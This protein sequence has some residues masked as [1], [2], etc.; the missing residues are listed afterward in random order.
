MKKT[1]RLIKL[2]NGKSIIFRTDEN[3]EIGHQIIESF[4]KAIPYLPKKNLDIESQDTWK[5]ILERDIGNRNCTYILDMIYQNVVTPIEEDIL[6][7]RGYPTKIRKIMKYM[8]DEIVNNRIDDWNDLGNLRMRTSELF[9]SLLT[10]QVNAA[11]NEYHSKILGGDQE[12][13]LYLNP[14][15]IFSEI[16]NSQ[17]VSTLENINPMEELAS[18]TK[19]T[20]IGIGGIAKLEAW[21][22][23][24]M[25]IHGSYYGN[26]DPYETPNAAGI[27]ILQHLTLGAAVTNTRGLFAERSRDKI[28][29]LEISSVG[30]SM[31]PFVESTDG[32]RVTMAAGQAKQAVPLKNPEIP[33]IQSGFESTFTNYLSDSFIKR[34]PVDGEVTEVTSLQIS[35][36][37]KQTRK[38]NV[39]D[40]SAVELKSG[41]GKSGLGVFN[42][43]VKQGEKVKKRQIIAEGSHIKNGIISTGLNCLAA[44]MPYLG[45]NFEDGMVI[46]QSLAKRFTSIHLEY[47][48]V[49]LDENDDVAYISNIGDNVHKGQI[50]LSYSQTAHDTDTLK[51]QRSENGI[52]INIEIYNN[53]ND[54]MVPEKL[55]D[56]YEDFKLRYMKL[57]GSY[58]IGQFKEKGTKVEGILVKFTIQQELIMKKG[59]KINNRFFNKG[60][61]ALIEK[62]ELMPKM[63]DGTPIEI[64]YSTLSVINRMNPSQLCEMHCSMISK[65]LAI[66]S[67]SLPRSRFV[68]LLS[69]V[70]N[71]LDS[72]KS[73]S[74]SKNMVTK[75]KSLS[76]KMYKNLLDEIEQT[77]FFPLVFPPFKSPD[78]QNILKAMDVIGV[79]TRY[80]L[81]LPRFNSKTEP[82]AV[83]YMYVSKLE[84]LSD[85][86]IHARSVGG[87][88]AGTL[89]PVAGKKRGG[90]QKLGEYDVY[91]L[92]A[93]DANIFIDE[94]LSAAA[95]DHI[96]KNE[97]ISSIL[98]TGEASFQ[99]SKSNPIKDNFI[100][101]LTAIH[102]EGG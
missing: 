23:K 42:P 22:Q 54:E 9:I 6:S 99:G 3:N 69:Q 39:V 14:T 41:Q 57:H 90:G 66:L 18:M 100:Q 88:K 62:D 21:P 2:P 56:I 71:L 7:L 19:I 28:N 27:G 50:I 101:M 24:A 60:V 83:G 63:P 77:Q 68:P 49:Y 38:L 95:D 47:H 51:H 15:K 52:I 44:W 30:P 12:A 5:D 58:P 40:I 97:L 10:K 89:Q 78:R 43:I 17:N 34:S 1:E 91:S 36:M 55:R 81:S 84:H 53:L 13:R 93:S 73:K 48:R 86:K 35:I 65:K 29:P 16:I 82:V 79:K 64:I 45:Y 75:F 25:N 85:K 32:P 61:V 70:L 92:L 72:S 59:D 4:N 102:L 98:H 96:V 31:L 80:P 20:P 74:Y 46:S 67:R 94:M 76:D 33:A 87:Y 8:C 11:Y 37:D 26:V